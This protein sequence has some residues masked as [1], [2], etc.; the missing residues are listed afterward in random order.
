MI[1]T[2]VHPGTNCCGQGHMT[3][4]SVMCVTTTY[5]ARNGLTS[6]YEHRCW[7][8]MGNCN[9]VSKNL[10][11]DAYQSNYKGNSRLMVMLIISIQLSAPQIATTSEPMHSNRCQ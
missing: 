11:R 3:L 9:M 7:F 1:W 4:W 10:E 6:L 5:Q 8:P 2:Q